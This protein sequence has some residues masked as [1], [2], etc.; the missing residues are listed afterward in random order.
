MATNP[1]GQ[2]DSIENDA[3]ERNESFGEMSYQFADVDFNPVDKHKDGLAYDS[4]MYQNFLRVII[5]TGTNDEQFFSSLNT[6]VESAG[7]FDESN[8]LYKKIKEITNGVFSSFKREHVKKVIK[9]MT[10]NQEII[11]KN[12]QSN[13][14]Y[15]FY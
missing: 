9:F 8:Q 10:H 12:C 7:V 5:N 2:L 13:Y 3:N 11:M 1:T 4:D 6:W 14:F 15:M